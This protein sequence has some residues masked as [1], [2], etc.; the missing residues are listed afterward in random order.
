M[1]VGWNRYFAFLCVVLGAGGLAQGIARDRI[2]STGPQQF[3]EYDDSRHTLADGFFK[4]LHCGDIFDEVL[5]EEAEVLRRD[6]SATVWFGPRMQWGYAAFGKPSPLQEPVIWDQLTMFDQSKEEL[7]FNHFLQRKPQVLI[8]FKNDL[9][10]YT[11]DEVQRILRQYSIDQ[12]F[13]VLTVLRL[14]N[15][16]P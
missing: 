9:T 6:P 15:E 7:Y 14:K 13:P 2:E 16:G 5:K 4:G 12:S 10:K 1:P 11:Q 8:L 3:F